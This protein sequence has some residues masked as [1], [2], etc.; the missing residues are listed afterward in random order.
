MRRMNAPPASVEAFVMRS[1]EGLHLL[2]LRLPAGAC[3]EDARLFRERLLQAQRRPST[4]MRS[5]SGG[6]S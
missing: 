5:L 2:L 6:L 3:L 1:Q 4:C